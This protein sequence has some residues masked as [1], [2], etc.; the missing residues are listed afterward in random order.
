MNPDE[1]RQILEAAGRDDVPPPSAE[2][3]DELERRLARTHVASGR[4]RGP[5]WPVI[6]AV[7]AA[8]VVVVAALVLQADEPPDTV[9]TDTSTSSTTTSSTTS[10]TQ[11]TTTSTTST[12]VVAPPTTAAVATTV[13]PTTTTTSAPPPTT[14]TTVATTTTTTAPPT[15]EDMRLSC[16]TGPRPE[17]TCTWSAST[18]ETFKGYVLTKRVGDGPT[19]EILRTT[20]RSLTSKTDK[21]VQTGTR[22][23][24]V[25][26]AIDRDGN[27]LGRA[28]ATVSCC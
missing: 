12:T 3:V 6:T 4:G 22:I 2:F 27:V 21:E 25:I 8:A 17:V 14:T 13:A 26:E 16:T 23:T 1:L 20:D 10:T 24:Y 15:V 19:E 9:L 11:A 5:R 18:A 28:E 7:A